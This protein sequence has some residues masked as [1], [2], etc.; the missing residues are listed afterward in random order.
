MDSA[1]CHL[2]ISLCFDPF[3]LMNPK[4]P[5]YSRSHI[6]DFYFYLCS[7]NYST[8][9]F[10]TIVSE[11][12]TCE[13]LEQKARRSEVELG[14]AGERA[15]AIFPWTAGPGTQKNFDPKHL[16]R[17]GRARRAEALRSFY[18]LLIRSVFLLHPPIPTGR[19]DACLPCI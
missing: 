17:D 15:R 9:I 16:P 12:A 11:W 13:R 18:I 3:V 6:I 19:K 5:P 7:L 14:R 4:A 8:L 1:S 10:R 2:P